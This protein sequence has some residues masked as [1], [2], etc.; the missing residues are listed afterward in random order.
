MIK[1]IITFASSLERI[2]IVSRWNSLDRL[3]RSGIGFQSCSL[4]FK[5]INLALT[6]KFL[7][8]MCINS[9]VAL[10]G[11]IFFHRLPSLQNPIPR[12]Y[13]CTAKSFPSIHPNERLGGSE[14]TSTF[15]LS[16]RCILFKSLFRIFISQRVIS[17]SVLQSSQSEKMRFEIWREMWFI[18]GC[19]GNLII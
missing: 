17:M 10:W 12:R 4:E 3:S 1:Q 6:I 7:P 2:R 15:I 19:K 9:P 11:F 8:P 18:E 16:S 13:I 5:F 14:F